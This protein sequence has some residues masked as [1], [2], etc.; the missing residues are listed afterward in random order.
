M[1]LAVPVQDVPLVLVPL[2][3]EP[4]RRRTA[5]ARA[6]LVQPRLSVVIVNY[7]QWRETAEL[8]GQ[9]RDAECVRAGLA[10]VVIVDNH[11]PPNR[12]GAQLRALPEV[13]LR[14]WGRN[15][16]FARA[17]NEGCRLGRGDWCLLLNP[18]T[19][20]TAG[21]LDRVLAGAEALTAR[22]PRTGIIGFQ[23]R[24]S[25]GSLQW[26][27]GPFPNLVGTLA[28]MARARSRRKYRALPLRRPVK[29]SWLTG[30]CLL[31]RRD[32]LQD[33]GGFDEGFFLYYED[34]DFCR[35]ARARGWS[36]WYDPTVQVIHHR[37]LHSRAV[38]APL[39]VVTRHALL[40]YAFRHW[41]TWQASLLARVVQVE[42]RL[43]KTWASW[44]NRSDEARRFGELVAIASDMASGEGTSARR[45]LRL[46]MRR[47]EASG[48]RK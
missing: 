13:S 46:M 19:S 29:A 3:A 7:R 35:R 21:F 20:V 38:P 33:L 27:S 16:G 41:P 48:P 37:P 26:S 8:V 11:S 25:D 23:L 40:H 17:V 22:D 34:V 14:R 45:R 31:V 5:T 47:E 36:V 24:N 2:L 43:R 32:C 44:R 9:L 39:R 15:R 10:E 30:C 28:G 18:D 1:A 6:A 12:L 4:H 42:A